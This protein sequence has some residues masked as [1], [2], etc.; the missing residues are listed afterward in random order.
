MLAWR[1]IPRGGGPT[2]RG[3]AQA[4]PSSLAFSL[5][6]LLVRE[7]VLLV[8]LAQL[9]QPLHPL[10]RHC[11]SRGWCDGRAGLSRRRRLSG[12]RRL[13]LFRLLRVVVLLGRNA[14]PGDCGGAPSALAPVSSHQVLL[15]S[16]AQTRVASETDVP[17]GFRHRPDGTIS[18]PSST[19]TPTPAHGHTPGVFV[20]RQ[21][22]N[23]APSR[24][25]SKLAPGGHTGGHKCG[26]AARIWRSRADAGG[27]TRTPDT[28]IM[29]PR[30]FGSTGPKTWAGGQQRGHN[31]AVASKWRSRRSGHRPTCH[32]LRTAGARR[33]CL[34]WDSIAPVPPLVLDESGSETGANPTLADTW[35][36]SRAGVS[37]VR[38]ATPA[39]VEGNSQQVP[40]PRVCRCSESSDS[41]ASGRS[42]RCARTAPL[43]RSRSLPRRSSSSS[44]AGASPARSR[45][46]HL[47]GYRQPGDHSRK[48]PLIHNLGTLSD[49][50][51]PCRVGR[52]RAARVVAGD[53]EAMIRLHRGRRSSLARGRRGPLSGA[54]RLCDGRPRGKAVR[55]IGGP[56]C[57][58]P[59]GRAAGAVRG[60]VQRVA[61]GAA[62]RGRASSSAAR[63]IWSCSLP[64]A[65]S[66]CVSRAVQT[67][68]RVD[69]QALRH[70]PDVGRVSALHRGYGRL[71]RAPRVRRPRHR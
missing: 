22:A 1:P 44:E 54:I 19:L 14:D 58:G 63:G 52:C 37:C 10:G 57:R 27:G 42:K 21:L 24:R 70:G 7:H 65:W 56:R 41:A 5:L 48:V 32:E 34:A 68:E 60:M 47:A 49:D 9:L 18:V 29:I 62:G 55:R 8:E 28:R 40:A 67:A 64:A 3:V 51:G 6:E 25:P 36:S 35:S 26:S 33:R 4:V 16:D 38:A 11:A 50:R 39:S 59:G 31:R 17:R 20:L 43:P 66:A 61:R 15:V 13:L 30:R 23:G 12:R 46:S 69:Q 53:W 71:G 45:R 2:S